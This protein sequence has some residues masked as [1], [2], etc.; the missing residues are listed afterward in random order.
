[1]G[2]PKPASKS[3]V[4]FDA[5]PYPKRCAHRGAGKLAPENTLAAFRHGASF[6][7][8]MFEFDAKLSGDG[9]ALLMHDPTL[10]RTSNGL[11]RVAGKTFGELSQLDAGSWHSAAYA[12]ETIPSLEAIARWL[13]AN[14]CLANIEIK[15][16]PGRDA[17]TG[18]AIALE[19]QRLFAGQ[20]IPP[21]LSS[22]SEL[23]LEAARQAVPELPRGLL[24]NQ[25]SSDWVARCKRLECVAIDPHYSQLSR[26]MIALAHAEGLRVATYTV[27]DLEM[28]ERLTSW[29]LDVLITDIVDRIKP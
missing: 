8:K 5:W 25:L 6:G 17:E 15:P 2:L 24:V 19:A 7:Y 28:A 9:V 21:L 10:E 18:A 1:M 23:A 22:F 12:G 20:S 27:N 3:L 16:C 13:N 11:G 4:S 29:G 14:H 26:E